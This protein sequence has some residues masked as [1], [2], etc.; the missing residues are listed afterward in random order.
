MDIL[1]ETLPKTAVRRAGSITHDG[2]KNPVT[3]I[4]DFE[5][6]TVEQ[7]LYIAGKTLKTDLQNQTRT[8]APDSPERAAAKAAKRKE[9]IAAGE[10]TVKVRERGMRFSTATA[11]TRTMSIDE[12]A[13]AALE[14]KKEAEKMKEA[15]R[16]AG[17]L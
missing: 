12:M 13:E 10:Y 5:G 9:I 8:D 11:V 3:L 4:F 6:V 15:L 7:A 2:V 16:K 1:K 17:L 14:D